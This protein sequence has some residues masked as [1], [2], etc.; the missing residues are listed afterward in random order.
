[1]DTRLA[2]A[3]HQ[4]CGTTSTPV[5]VTSSCVMFQY[6]CVILGKPSG[7]LCAHWAQDRAPVDGAACMYEVVSLP[8]VPRLLDCSPSWQLACSDA[9]ELSCGRRSPCGA[10]EA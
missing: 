2:A 1:M 7:A 3:E 9:E 4:Y 10:W 6:H 8:Q 5:G